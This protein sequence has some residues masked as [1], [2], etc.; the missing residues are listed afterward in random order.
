[1]ATLDFF[2]AHN[3]PSEISDQIFRLAGPTALAN[4]RCTNRANAEAYKDVALGFVRRC[5]WV[6]NASS[7]AALQVA[8]LNKLPCLRINH[9]VAYSLPF[10]TAF[11][12]LK[13]LYIDNPRL[14]K[15]GDVEVHGPGRAA[16]DEYVQAAISMLP[17][18]L[19]VLECKH[20]FLIEMPILPQSLE[21]LV[22]LEDCHGFERRLAAPLPSSLKSLRV[23]VGAGGEYVS[24]PAELPGSLEYLNIN[25]VRQRSGTLPS[26]PLSL[27][28]L[29]CKGAGLTH[30]PDL[31]ASLVSLRCRSN[32]ISALPNLPATLE[33]LHCNFNRLE[34]LP[35]PLPP[36][37]MELNCA[38]NQ[39]FSLPELP[40]SVDAL[41][42]F[43]QQE[44]M[45][46]L[47][48]LPVG[49]KT[50]YCSGNKLEYLPTLPT[51]LENLNCSMNQLH[52]LPELPGR[53]DKL[54]CN[55]N[56]LP[57]LPRLPASLQH[58]RCDFDV[59]QG[60]VLPRTLK[61]CAVHNVDGVLEAIQLRL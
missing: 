31:P 24:L 20:C 14:P 37:L 23:N 49:L 26:L 43:N 9:S 54:V 4:F 25:C 61:S 30:L 53:L 38:G 47:P 29:S 1:M 16:C 44:G 41:R 11:D 32:R 8:R 56:P 40:P 55:A 3:I 60:L 19:V 21:R 45:G 42:C 39:L 46:H 27:R 18:R 10:V 57:H 35:A 22:W 48:E 7:P 2:R 28:H 17:Q 51:G 6:F 59:Y 34:S 36:G 5:Q 58:L 12:W 33:Y 52:S 13:E 50:L 15:D